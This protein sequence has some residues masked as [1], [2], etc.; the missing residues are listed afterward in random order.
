M[1][2]ANERLNRRLKSSE[3]GLL[4]KLDMEI[5]YD[6]INW[7]FIYYLLLGVV[8]GRSGILAQLNSLCC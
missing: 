3:I 2:I 8:L 6:N 7:D 5:A 4:C 1:L